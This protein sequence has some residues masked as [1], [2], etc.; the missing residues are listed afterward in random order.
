MTPECFA[1]NTAWT[2]RQHSS[3]CTGAT[4]SRC[5]PTLGDCRPGVFRSPLVDAWLKTGS[6]RHRTTVGARFIV[7]Q[8]GNMP[9]QGRR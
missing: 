7:T 4:T 1:G 5:M 2:L 9:S 6:V 3:E 8:T